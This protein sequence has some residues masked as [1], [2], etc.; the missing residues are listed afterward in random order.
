ML[1]TFAQLKSLEALVKEQES[2]KDELY[3]AKSDV[4]VAKAKLESHKQSDKFTGSKDTVARNLN[5]QVKAAE[6]NVS[7]IEYELKAKSYEIARMAYMVEDKG[8]KSSDK[9]K[10]NGV[11]GKTIKDMSDEELDRVSG[12]DKV[13]N[14]DEQKEIIENGIKEKGIKGYD[15]IINEVE[16][17]IKEDDDLVAKKAKKSEAAK[18]VDTKKNY[19]VITTD[20][21]DMV[22]HTGSD[23]TT[24]L[25]EAMFFESEETA[26]KNLRFIKKEMDE[27]LGVDQVPAAQNAKLNKEYLIEDGEKAIFESRKD[28]RAKEADAK[29]KELLA[30]TL[31][32]I[33]ANGDLYYAGTKLTSKIE[34]ALVYTDEAKANKIAEK[35]ATKY[36]DA[37][38]QEV[39]AKLKSKIP[40]ENIDDTE[41]EEG[42]MHNTKAKKLGEKKEREEKAAAKKDAF[43]KGRY[44]GIYVW[45]DDE[46][47]WLDSENGL[48]RDWGD[49]IFF[50]GPNAA[51]A[52]IRS[53]DRFK[54]ME[55]SVKSI[56]KSHNEDLTPEYLQKI[57]ERKQAPAFDKPTTKKAWDAEDTEIAGSGNKYEDNKN[58]YKYRNV[59]NANGRKVAESSHTYNSKEVDDILAQLLADDSEED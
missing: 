57:S 31:Y 30:K 15:T 14:S 24:K 48:T 47:G 54:G 50:E 12:W 44:F 16:A 10:G 27:D 33:M 9:P 55:L 29:Y 58:V 56:D 38:A 13:K 18:K 32:V 11:K 36:E 35:L 34:D 45:T 52:Y 42:L 28:K 21:G 22:D 19:W 37:E 1:I 51:K 26:K 4:A 59:G 20:D 41:L 53:L 40:M 39:H 49:M 5:K 2:L 25:S 17:D 3:D 6:A 46:S 7:R 43:L 23:I 8:Y